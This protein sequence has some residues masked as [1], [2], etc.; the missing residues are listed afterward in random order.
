MDQRL[1]IEILAW[2]DMSL[3][4]RVLMGGGLAHDLQ[5]NQLQG[6]RPLIMSYIWVN[7]QYS[8]A[9]IDHQKG[10]FIV[11]VLNVR[12]LSNTNKH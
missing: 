11:P 9:K 8:G 12:V 7:Q 10:G 5:Q 1:P 2:G 4:P 3:P 6:H